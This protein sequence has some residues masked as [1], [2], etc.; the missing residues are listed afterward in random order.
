VNVNLEEYEVKASFAAR[1]AQSLARHDPSSAARASSS[2]Y[3]ATSVHSGIASTNRSDDAASPRT[4]RNIFVDR[5]GQIFGDLPV[6]TFPS[7]F[8][9]Q[10]V[11]CRLAMLHLQF[12]R[13][14]LLAPTAP[15]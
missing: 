12:S 5:A 15:V 13:S 11:V 1:F 9:R 7:S 14:P 2:V 4:N 6:G 10:K 8:V 3:F